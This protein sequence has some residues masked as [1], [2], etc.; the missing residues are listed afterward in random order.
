MS[1]VRGAASRRTR[2]LRLAT[3][4]P[5]SPSRRL[6]PLLSFSSTKSPK[7]SSNRSEDDTSACTA[8]RGCTVLQ[9]ACTASTL[10]AKPSAHATRYS[11][12]ISATSRKALNTAL[13]TS[14]VPR[15]VGRPA[16][17]F[18]TFASVVPNRVRKVAAPTPGVR[19]VT[20]DPVHSCRIAHASGACV[21]STTTPDDDNA[22]CS[23]AA[24]SVQASSRDE[25]SPTRLPRHS[26]AV[27]KAASLSTMSTSAAATANA[28]P[29]WRWAAA[30]RRHSTSASPLACTTSQ[31]KSAC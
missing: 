23:N 25:S 30:R 7:R 28:V 12:G 10:T 8:G 6:L 4:Q 20:S 31:V 13:A 29:A 26:Q 9:L 27:A 18:A 11:S 21:S 17:F 19:G 16:I 24:M 5:F 3:S 14:G 1:D 2:P 22:R 15:H